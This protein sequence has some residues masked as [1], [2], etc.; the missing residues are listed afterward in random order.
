MNLIFSAIK[1][2][3][4]LVY[5]EGILFFCKTPKEHTDH[6]GLVLRRLKDVGVKLSLKKS[7]FFSNSIDYSGQV[8]RPGELDKV[9]HT[10]DDIWK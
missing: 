9:A 2:Q 4:A 7:A 6:K 10:A 8:I 1:W 3:Y 5:L